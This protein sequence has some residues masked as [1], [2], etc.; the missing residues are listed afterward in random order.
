MAIQHFEVENILGQTSARVPHSVWHLYWSRNHL[1]H[2][3]T[4]PLR[5]V[6]YGKSLRCCDHGNIYMVCLCAIEVAL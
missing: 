1:A 3:S 5:D 6:A 4:M 2:R